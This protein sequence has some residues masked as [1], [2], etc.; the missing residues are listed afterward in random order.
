MKKRFFI[1]S[2]SLCLLLPVT[3]FTIIN[4][5]LFASGTI[6]NSPSNQAVNRSEERRVGKEC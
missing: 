1:L 3:V 6:I 4:K 2:I 5:G